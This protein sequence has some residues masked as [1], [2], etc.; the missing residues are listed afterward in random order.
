MSTYC[1]S[2]TNNCNSFDRDSIETGDIRIGLRCT[3]INLK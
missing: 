3:I 2:F 1:C